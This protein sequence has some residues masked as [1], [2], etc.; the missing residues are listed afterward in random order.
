MIEVFK[1]TE[2][3]IE[4]RK[5]IIS[6]SNSRI[7]DIYFELSIKEGSI[8]NSWPLCPGMKIPKVSKDSYL[9]RF[10][11]PNS[12]YAILDKFI[13]EKL[14]EVQDQMIQNITEKLNF[15]K[16]LGNCDVQTLQEKFG[17]TQVEANRWLKCFAIIERSTY[18]TEVL[19]YNFGYTLE[20]IRD[21]RWRALEVDFN[22]LKEE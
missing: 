1:P 17:L 9:F 10:D 14:E 5:T 11:D 6:H 12:S 16:S 13:K 20:E 22:S 18:S 19:K 2:P 21:L 7:G 15:V 8:K 4:A 3:S